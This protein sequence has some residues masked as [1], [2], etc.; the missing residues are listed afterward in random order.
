M[1]PMG[2]DNANAKSRVR[3]IDVGNIPTILHGHH[4]GTHCST[5][6]RWCVLVGVSICLAGVVCS[7]NDAPSQKLLMMHP[8]KGMKVT[9][10]V[11]T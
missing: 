11:D 4:L 6:L 8:L 1:P 7:C 10:A 2:K 9:F 5:A 3:K